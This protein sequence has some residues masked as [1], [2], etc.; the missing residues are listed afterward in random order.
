MRNKQTRNKT[1]VGE[2]SK[3]LEYLVMAQVL[4]CPMTIDLHGHTLSIAGHVMCSYCTV[5]KAVL[6]ICYYR[7]VLLWMQHLH[8]CKGRPTP[9]PATLLF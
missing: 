8:W 1:V 7:G 5:C 4:V 6:K 3:L 2:K 9:K